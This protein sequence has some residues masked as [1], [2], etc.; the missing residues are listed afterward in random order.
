MGAEGAGLIDTQKNERDEVQHVVLRECDDGN[1]V[2]TG[3]ARNLSYLCN[4]SMMF[5][6]QWRVIST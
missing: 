3:S 2:D 5:R 1:V 4:H 6:R